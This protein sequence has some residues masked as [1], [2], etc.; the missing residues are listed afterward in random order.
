MQKQWLI[1][2]CVRAFI[3][4]VRARCHWMVFV[5]NF[6]LTLSTFCATEYSQKAKMLLFSN[7]SRIHYVVQIQPDAHTWCCRKPTEHMH[8]LHS[9]GKWH[10]IYCD[11]RVCVR[12]CVRRENG[13]VFLRTSLLL[14]T[15]LLP[16]E[17]K[18]RAR[19]MKYNVYGSKIS[20]RFCHSQS[21]WNQN[22][23]P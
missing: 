7:G 17:M 10:F 11:L 18:R 3:S 21:K 5:I 9:N 13:V 12:L 2:C 6:H 22:K 19:K 23:N 14:Y 16:L 20:K 8:T 1:R 15:F 4:T